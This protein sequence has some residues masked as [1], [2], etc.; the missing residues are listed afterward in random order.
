M[1]TT[2]LKEKITVQDVE[3]LMLQFEKVRN[4]FLKRN[5]LKYKKIVPKQNIENAKLF[6]DFFK[7]LYFLRKI[8][9]VEKIDIYKFFYAQ[10]FISKKEVYPKMLYSDWAINNY[11]SFLKQEKK[12]QKNIRNKIITNN[13]VDMIYKSRDVL[14]EFMKRKKIHFNVWGKRINYKGC[15]MSLMWYLFLTRKISS[16]FL[17]FTDKYKKELR[18]MINKN[19]ISKSVFFELTIARMKIIQ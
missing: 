8:Q 6:N 13:I 5:N 17:V 12:N 19:L 16:Y 11:Y 9:E 18:Y 2:N 1:S 14:I 10:F 3:S 7:L 15:Q 4:S